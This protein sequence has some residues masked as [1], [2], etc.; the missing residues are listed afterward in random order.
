MKNN[1]KKKLTLEE[2]E[3]TYNEKGSAKT[4]KAFL[5]IFA[6]SIGLVIFTCL[7]VL[8]LKAFDVHLYFGIASGAV[9][10]L[11]FILLYI[12]PLVKITRLEQF[13]VRVN[14]SNVHESIRHNR[15]MRKHLAEKIVE[16][17]E[18]VE[19]CLWYDDVN[20]EALK[21]A[22]IANDN[23]LIKDTLTKLYS[24][25]IKKAS[26]EMIVRA[27]LKCGG[28]TALSQDNKI[29][30]AIVVAINMTLIKDIV[31]LYGFRPSDTKMA[32]IFMTVLRNSL[33]AYGAGNAKIG[34]GIASTVS[35]AF[36]S[37]PILGNLI[38]TVVDSTVNG[39]INGILTVTLGFEAIRYL[40][41]EY[42]L[43]D[44][45]DGVVVDEGQAGFDAAAKEV[46]AGLTKLNEKKA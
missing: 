37:I 40:D 27:A 46:K 25:P 12:V 23:E 6:A 17:H 41:K 4:A 13:K 8:V 42:K 33:V 34:A 21:G 29:D 30:T 18:N 19:E 20:V 9:A 26:H 3:R 28:L 44:V 32:K 11:L 43:Q 45:L 14:R 38:G 15:K 24:K 1:E 35:G 22:L 7:L 36:Q 2:Y 31:Y 5:T 10:L 16:V 39:L